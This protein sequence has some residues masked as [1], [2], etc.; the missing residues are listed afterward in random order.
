[1]SELTPDILDKNLG[2]DQT[3][4]EYKEKMNEYHARHR[5]CPIC[6][7]DRYSSTCMAYIMHNL[8][9]YRDMNI[10]DCRC[11][12]RGYKHDLVPRKVTQNDK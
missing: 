2:I 8:E 4:R 9:D 6:G 5:V 1:M 7:S 3:R 10:I 11:G 12:Y